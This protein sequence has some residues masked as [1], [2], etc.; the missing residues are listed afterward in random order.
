MKE[1]TSPELE[2]IRFSP[3]DAIC[4]SAKLPDPGDNETP[5][6]PFG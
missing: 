2:L 6:V 5:I 1:Y 3:E 4:A